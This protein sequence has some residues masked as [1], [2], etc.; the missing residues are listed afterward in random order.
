MCDKMLIDAAHVEETRVV[1]TAGKKVEEFDFETARKQRVT[2]NIYLAKVTRVEQGLQASFVDF[3]RDRHGFLAFS[4]VHPDYYQIPVADRERLLS[5]AISASVSE[6][7]ADENNVNDSR[8]LIQSSKENGSEENDPEENGTE[9]HDSPLPENNDVSR[10]AVIAETLPNPDAVNILGE[11]L[12]DEQECNFLNFQSSA[13]SG[14]SMLVVG[15]NTDGVALSFSSDDVRKQDN[16]S[17]EDSEKFLN[18]VTDLGDDS[19]IFKSAHARFLR[20]VMHRY[21]IQEVIKKRQIL[22]V[23]VLKEERGNKGAALTTYISL[24]GRYCVLMPNTA[25][26]GGI[27]KKITNPSDRKRLKS[28]VQGL[29]IPKGMGLIIRTAGANRTKAEIKRDYDYLLRHWDDIRNRT[30]SSIAPDLIYEEGSLIK[31]S[32]RDLYTKNIQEILVEGDAGYREA[33]DFMR[34]L[35]PSHARYVKPYKNPTPIFAYHGV[36]KQLEDMFSPGVPLKSGGYIVFGFT[37]ALTSVDVNSGKST[38][39]HSIE[40]T[41]LKTNLE[42]AEELARQLRLRDLAGLIVVDFIDMGD[43]RNCRAVEKMLK[44]KL[45]DERARIQIG[46]ISSFGLLEMSRQRIRPSVMD[47]ASMTCPHCLGIGLVRSDES[48]ALS[49]LRDIEGRTI[50]KKGKVFQVIAPVSIVNF[51]IN[52]KRDHV[53][54]LEQ[55]ADVSLLIEASASFQ[56]PHYVI[57]VLESSEAFPRSAGSLL[58][59]SSGVVVSTTT[60]PALSV[61]EETQESGDSVA[62]AGNKVKKRRRRKRKRSDSVDTQSGADPA[63]SSGGEVSHTKDVLAGDVPPVSGEESEQVVE[64]EAVSSKVPSEAS[65][66]PKRRNRQRKNNTSRVSS[67]EASDMSNESSRSEIPKNE[68]PKNEVPKQEHKKHTDTDTEVSQG[69]HNEAN[70]SQNIPSDDANTTQLRDGNRTGRRGGWWNFR[71]KRD[72]NKNSSG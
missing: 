56:T 30:L 22:L 37:E 9:G 59:V 40:E 17:G 41:A 15:G 10:T 52:N 7:G 70:S 62:P 50:G 1:T 31:R 69:A 20:E 18:T 65:S 58:E 29:E 57:N 5:L 14:S 61:V 35:M 46:R 21:K 2:G 39:E 11:P 67:H 42:A 43:H 8:E 51:L 33:K 4:E 13:E 48:L 26:G 38:R 60:S 53:S 72:G 6:G 47:S 55:R 25:R 45:R 27:S 3:G 12:L 28:V 34:M 64:G 66:P 63:V 71:N 19:E 23:Q 32:I 24:A 54:S 44:D 68:I 36:E 49:I 16:S